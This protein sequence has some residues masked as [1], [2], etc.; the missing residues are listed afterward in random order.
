MAYNFIKYFSLNFKML[1]F[2]LHIFTEQIKALV[3]IILVTYESFIAA[4]VINANSFL[5]S[6]TSNISCN[7]WKGLFL[8]QNLTLI[9][10]KQ[11]STLSCDLL[12]QYTVKCTLLTPIQKTADEHFSELPYM[13]V[14]QLFSSLNKWNG[15]Y[16]P[17]QRLSRPRPS[18]DTLLYI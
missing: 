15:F 1:T 8:Q 11:S 7:D 9:W 5:M 16:L 6:H 14:F 10:P 17:L 13:H 4:T 2:R 3:I 18:V 12:P